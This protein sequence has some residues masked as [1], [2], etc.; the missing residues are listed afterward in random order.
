VHSIAASLKP[1]RSGRFMGPTIAIHALANLRDFGGVSNYW[2][3][4]LTHPKNFK[5]WH[6]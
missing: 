5:Q 1:F 2:A 4:A 3:P 6:L